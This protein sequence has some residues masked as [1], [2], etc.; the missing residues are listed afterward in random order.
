MAEEARF[1]EAERRLW[2]SVSVTPAEQ[3]VR[4]ERSGATVRIQEVG[5]GEPVLFLHGVSNSGSSWADL[6]VRMQGY[7]CLMVDK[8]GTGLSDAFP[9]P[10][11]FDSLQRFADGYVGEVLD[12]LGLTTAH[13]V[14]TSYGGYAAIRSAAAHP[15]RI[16]RIVEFGWMTGAPAAPMPLVMRL[17]TIP[18]LGRAMAK[19]PASEGAVRAMFKQIGLREALASGR[20]SKESLNWYRALL[21]HTDTMRNELEIGP[22]LITTKGMDERIYLSNEFLASVQT[23][24]CFLW[25]ENDPFGGAEVARA[26]TAK[27][28]NAELELL[29]G[30]GHAVW[31]DDPDKAAEVATSFLGRSAASPT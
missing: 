20:L 8:P 18:W 11:T 10:F 4:L 23:P 15:E 21:N 19:L 27:I 29:P 2:D 24:M 12:A 30:A 22:R 31:M 16:G 28:P 25:G 13:V 1:R 6:V 7:R 14:A 26:F 3:R 9:V 5:E 17:V